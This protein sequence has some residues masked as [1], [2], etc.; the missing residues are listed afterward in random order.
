[1]RINNVGTLT[2]DGKQQ[3]ANTVLAG[4]AA[5]ITAL[6]LPVPMPK[7]VSVIS[8]GR[9]RSDLGKN[10]ALKD[11]FAVF[12]RNYAVDPD[13][14]SHLGF[15]LRHERL[16]LLALKR[17]FLAVPPQE[18]TDFVAAAPRTAFRRQAWFFYEWLTGRRI[19]PVGP[20]DQLGPY[21][22]AIDATQWHVGP[23][24][25]SPRH[26]VVNN[27][28]GTPAFC[29]MMP[30]SVPLV[31][32]L[33]EAA[34]A[35]LS[36]IAGGAGERQLWR[37]RQ[38]LLLKDS[39]STFLIE[40]EIPTPGMTQNWA[41]ELAKAGSD[42]LDLAFIVRL[43]TLLMSERRHVTPGLRRDGVFLGEH[44]DGVPVPV[45]IGARPEDLPDLMDGLLETDRRMAEGGM[46]PLVQ[47]ATTAFGMVLIHPLED[48]NG[49]LHRYLLQQVLGRRG[50]K[51]LGITLPISKAIWSDL[52]GYIEALESCQNDRFDQI[53]WRATGNGNVEV[54]NDTA[55]LYRFFDPSAHVRF[56][57]KCIDRVLERDIPDELVEMDRRDRV[58]KR[59]REILDMPERLVDRFVQFTLQND[60]TLSKSKRKKDFPDLTDAD[61]QAM[62]NLVRE[63]FEIDAPS[64]DPPTP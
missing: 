60:G 25:R 63:I 8:E 13:F 56:L 50:I 16:D 59:V 44:V 52:D 45:W 10:H 11:G 20:G 28:P 14:G 24:V 1:M 12:E 34:T 15:A 36:K 55:D 6:R 5:L 9:H 43:Q 3:P 54:I 18:V 17:I 62:Q 47:A 40:K 39:K 58:V 35:R 49:R 19:E 41:N 7:T 38:R 57:S 37:L 61:V 64:I 22:D 51:P 23:A 32:D 53:Q 48:G 27:L 21:V 30:R 26:R 46:H 31:D 33:A 4:Y 42:P 2:I 29:P